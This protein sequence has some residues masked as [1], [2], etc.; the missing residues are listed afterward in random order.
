VIKLRR[1]DVVFEGSPSKHLNISFRGGKN[2]LF[3]EGGQRIV[4]AFDP[5]SRYCPVN[6]TKSYF[7]YLG[8][9]HSGFLIPCCDPHFKPDQSKP[10][11][12]N[13]ALSDL[14]SLLDSLG[15][16]G[17]DYGEHSG[18]RGGASAAAE[19]G[20]SKDDLQRLGGWRSDAMPSKYTDLTTN[21]RLQMSKYLQKRL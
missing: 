11:P 20:I 9:H 17:K 4:A 7:Q 2:D 19:N 14:R 8:S 15:Y 10:V 3:S 16:Q 12:Y 21:S 18:K 5:P 13:A 1:S 6:F